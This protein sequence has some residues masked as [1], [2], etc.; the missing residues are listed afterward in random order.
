MLE[1]KGIQN[2]IVIDHIKAGNGLKIFNKLL[3]ENIENPVVLLMNVDSKVLGK[4][5]IIKLADVFEIDF[6]ILGLIDH[7]ITVNIVK[8][9]KIIDKRKATV[10]DEVTGLFQCGNPRCITNSDAYAIPKFKLYEKNGS[11][12]YICS[13]CEE[14]TKYRL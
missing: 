14:I 2:G 11:A 3:S 10:P 5:D 1:V 8:D 13:Y 9:S 4:K 7:N 12:E 6:D